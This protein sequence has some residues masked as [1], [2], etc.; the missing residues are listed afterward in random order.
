MAQSTN[1]ISNAQIKTYLQLNPY[2]S[3]GS[4][5]RQLKQ[6]LVQEWLTLFANDCEFMQT[7]DV[8]RS[9]FGIGSYPGNV[10]GGKM[11][12]L[13]SFSDLQNLTNHAN[14]HDAIGEQSFTELNRDNLLSRV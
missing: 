14:Y 4:F 6:I 11:F 13:F 9:C 12:R 5:E 7:G 10:T 1:I 2:L 3:G 8:E